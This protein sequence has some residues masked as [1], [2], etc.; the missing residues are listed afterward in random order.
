MP[1][2]SPKMVSFLRQNWI[3]VSI[4]LVACA[5]AI[6]IGANV[7]L[8]FIYFNDPRHQDEILKGWMTPRYIVMSYDLP[9]GVVMDMLDI[10]SEDKHGMRLRDVAQ[11]MGVTL[12]E[13]TQIVRDGAAKY[14]AAGS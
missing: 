4:L 12:E 9:R 3:V 5:V 2:I 7:V 10:G 14:R 11:N 8:D 6:W 1:T 13:L